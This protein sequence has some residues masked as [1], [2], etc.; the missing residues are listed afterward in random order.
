MRKK[1]PDDPMNEDLSQVT[2]HRTRA[3]KVAS[4]EHR[5]MKE[6]TDNKNGMKDFV[7]T[8]SQK[9]LANKIREHTIVFVNSEA[10]TGKSSAVLHYFCKEYLLDPSKQI[11]I[12]RTPVEAG[13][14]KIG[15]L[16]N[17]EAE[18]LAVHFSSARVLLEQFL[19]KNRVEA[20]FEK[21]IFFKAPN[22]M[23]GSTLSNSLILIDEAQQ[24]QP[25]I[26]KLLLERTGKYSK[27]V[28]AGC[29]SQ[30]YTTDKSRNALADAEKQFFTFDGD[31]VEAK[32]PNIAYHE[33]DIDECH[34]DDVVKDVIRAYREV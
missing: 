24:L 4:G 29:S 10:G 7:P 2:R 5:V 8:A 12:I 6:Y 33:F 14:D 9:E 28:V 23:L 21:R 20:D 11:V 18:K 25:I 32:Y 31:F 22:F 34:R 1:T 30:I 27:V 16:P 17:S 13:G 3:G 26:L 19:G 15:F